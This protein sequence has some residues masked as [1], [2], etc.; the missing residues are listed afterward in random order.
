[1]HAHLA[2]P[3]WTTITRFGEAGILLPCA[4]LIAV[5]LLATTREWRAAAAWVL[6]LGIAVAVTTASK[7]AFLGFGL[8]I[9]SLDF[10]GFSGHAMFAAAVY[11]ML[12][13]A[14]M[15]R[16][17]PRLRAVVI[18][19]AYALAALVAVSRVRVDAHSPSEIVLGFTLGALASAA[20]MHALREGAEFTLPPVLAGVLALWLGLMPHEPVLLPSHEIVT[21]VSLKL[22]GRTK[23]FTRADLHRKGLPSLG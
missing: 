2:S 5:G 16:G 9:A 1:M 4:A 21:R 17:R 18:A 6:P 11:P 14:L 8:G 10:T 23:P 12:A 20:A 22:S 13:W 3:F 15:G 7:I 19:F